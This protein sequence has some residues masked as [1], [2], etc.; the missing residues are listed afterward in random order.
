MGAP[1]RKFLVI[2]DNVDNRFLL[3]RT[4]LRKYP[5]AVIIESGDL[6]AALEQVRLGGLDAV[7]S[8][9]AG[10]VDGLELLRELRAAHPTVP[11][12]MVSGYDRTRAALEA[13]ATCFLNYDEWLRLGTVIDEILAGGPL[14]A[15]RAALSHAIQ[16]H[17]VIAFDYDAAG[18]PERHEVEPHLLGATPD[19]RLILRAH[20][21][22]SQR[23]GYAWRS[24]R[25]DRIANLQFTPHTFA[26]HDG[27]SNPDRQIT[28]VLCHT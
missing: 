27:E 17:T 25:V 13:G 23:T 15:L 26:P 24:Y 3:T 2:D 4:V 5:Q 28:R 22:A 6:A 11:I 1:V 19:G 21:T 20:A 8:H 12:V 10:E 18:Q 7:I 9:R 16:S 14:A